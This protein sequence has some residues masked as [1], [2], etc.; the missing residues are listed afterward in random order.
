MKTVRRHIRAK[1]TVVDGYRFDSTGEAK[2]YCDLRMLERGGEI[3]N[4]EVHPALHMTINGR[5]LGRGWLTLDFK[6]E[7]E[8]EAGWWPVYED[9][10]AV[11]SRESKFRRQVAEAI[12]G[13][14][15]EVVSK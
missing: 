15:I 10:K 14:K 12:H 4:L 5:K 1:P 7:R 6:Y 9:F 2:R 11:D 8:E 3:R 13:I